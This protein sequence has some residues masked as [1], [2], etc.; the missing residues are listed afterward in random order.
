L[1]SCTRGLR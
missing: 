1:G